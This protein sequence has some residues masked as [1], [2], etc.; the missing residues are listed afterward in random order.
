MQKQ[1]E[2]LKS[3][4][5]KILFGI[6]EELS[7]GEDHKMFR[8]K[9]AEDLLRLLKADFFASFIWNPSTRSFGDTVVLNMSPDNLMQYEIHYQ[10][11]DPITH[12]LQ[13]RRQATLV[14]EVM[15]QEELEKTEFFNDF[16]MRDGLHHGINLYAYDRDLNIGDL[17]IW[18]STNRPAFDNQDVAVLNAILPYFRNALRNA[19]SIATARNMAGLWNDFLENTQVALFL[20]D[21]EDQFVF[22]NRSA[23]SLLAELSDSLKGRFYRVLSSLLK[24]DLCRTEWG[25]FSLSVFHSF[26]PEDGRPV[27]GIL[28]SRS[29]PPRIDR[30]ILLSRFELTPREIDICLLICKGLTDQEIASVLNIAFSTVRTHLKHTFLKL[31][32]SNRSELISILFESVVEISY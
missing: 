29:S 28:A 9:I 11:R 27:K 24:N 18:R 20:F 30:E 3:H 7:G 32:V 21:H 1:L 23:D 8:M 31:D 12:I 5:L 13:K 2:N 16:L 19:R 6:I 10:F 14:C 4:E 17:R 15:K 22:Q 26:S 25:S